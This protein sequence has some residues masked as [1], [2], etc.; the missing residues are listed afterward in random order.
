MHFLFIV[1]FLFIDVLIVID[2]FAADLSILYLTANYT[3]TDQGLCFLLLPLY[4][5]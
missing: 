1:H 3:S 5:D 4:P 2:C